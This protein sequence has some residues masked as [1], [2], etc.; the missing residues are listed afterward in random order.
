MGISYVFL[1]TEKGLAFLDRSRT[2]MPG[3]PT[4]RLQVKI[5]VIKSPT[6]FYEDP[7]LQ[8]QRQECTIGKNSCFWLLNC[9]KS[10]STKGKKND[11]IGNN[12]SH[13]HH[14]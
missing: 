3:T 6:S 10:N 12:F 4:Q 11:T 7:L 1:W 9:T 5:M 2:E 14:K 13:L 8:H